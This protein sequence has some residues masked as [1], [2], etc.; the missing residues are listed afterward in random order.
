MMTLWGAVL[1]R[2]EAAADLVADHRSAVTALAGSSDR[3]ISLVYALESGVYVYQRDLDAARTLELGGFQLKRFADAG[4]V[5][6]EL[7]ME[8]L[9]ELDTDLLVLI[10]P[11]GPD[12]A[13]EALQQQA[14]FEALPAVASG[15]FASLDTVE[16]AALLFPTTL[17]LPTV[18]QLFDRLHDL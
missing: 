2:D 11:Y 4:D 3:T 10:Q 12:A 14:L 18:G 1:G 15:R 9:D 13:A 17:A 8:R 6:F 16:S 7:S 5:S